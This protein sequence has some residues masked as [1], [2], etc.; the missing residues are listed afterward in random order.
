VL[1]TGERTLVF[2]AG[3]EGHLV[4]RE[5]ELAGRQGGFSFVRSG[6]AA[7]ERVAA[8]ASFL[9]DAESRLRGRGVDPTKDEKRP[10]NGASSDSH[11]GHP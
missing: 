10:S 1:A 11:E 3:E 7:G 8:E 2:V 5:I 6:L 4:A 9:V